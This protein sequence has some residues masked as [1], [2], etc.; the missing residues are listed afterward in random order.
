MTP[1]L[2]H[3]EWTAAAPLISPEN[4]ITPAT[5]VIGVAWLL[6][7]LPIAGAVI[8]LVGGRRLDRVGHWLCIR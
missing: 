4:T 6:L 5:G 3:A 7:L 1:P 8:L 2:L